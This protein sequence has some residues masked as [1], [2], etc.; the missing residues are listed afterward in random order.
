[1]TE[2]SLESLV[3]E[4]L[5]LRVSDP[6]V[7]PE[8]F[9]AL[10]PASPQLPG[11][12]RSALEIE[13]LF[14]G[15]PPTPDAIGA[16][17]VVSELGRGGMGIVYRVEKG[18]REFA[19]KLLPMAPLVGPRI[20]E[21]FRREA[22]N[23]AQ[24]HHSSIVR[25]HET[26]LHGGMPYLVMDLVDG[27][28][29]NRHAE[30]LSI[31]AAA[32]LVREL[33]AA[34]QVV[35]DSGVLHRD[36]KP[37]NVL[38][39]ADGTTVL[40]DFG[41]SVNADVSG[42]TMTGEILGTPRYMAPEQVSAGVVDERTDVHALG[43]I[44][45]ELV[46]Q[47]PARSEASRD[48]VLRAARLGRIPRPRRVNGEIRAHL[49]RIVLTALAQKPEDRYESARAMGEDLD[50]YLSG[51]PVV[52]KNPGITWEI[53]ELVSA[54]P[55]RVTKVAVSV[56]VLG[57][58]AL[59]LTTPRPPSQADVA[60]A[61]RDR[62]QGIALW[63]DGREES[64]RSVLVRSLKRNPGDPAAVAL[65]RHLGGV[66]GRCM[67]S[68]VS[69]SAEQA[70]RLYAEGEFAAAGST[71]RS[72]PQADR[73]GALAG[74]VAALCTMESGDL[75][76]AQAELTLASR[77]LPA[78]VTLQRR[79]GRVYVRTGRLEEAERVFGHVTTL[80]PDSARSW[81]DLADV[82]LRRR[83]IEAGQ[84]AIDRALLID[85]D[86]P[87]SL[88]VLANLK[89]LSGEG[90][91][92]RGILS[93]LAEMRP[94]DPSIW[95]DLG[96][97]HDLD[98]DIVGAEKAYSRAVQLDTGHARALLCL[99]NL[100]AGASRGKCKGCDAAYAAHPEYIDL[101]KAETYL[102]RNLESDRARDAWSAQTALDIAL[103]LENRNRVIALLERLTAVPDKTGPII[104]LQEILG[105]L[106]LAEGR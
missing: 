60:A 14:G 12:I 26:G 49:E 16:Y 68:A 54:Y 101:A 34:V 2:E 21:R 77:R 8:S 82:G 24:L 19:L 39:R 6:T 95:F 69:D 15:L 64:A 87:T 37:Q 53:S 27:I 103:L 97:S 92:A 22:E 104:R 71:L 44:L 29:L 84:K 96:Y 52:A 105:R 81:R 75:T 5:D 88:R 78:S 7:T 85:P 43:L 91:E 62:D 17:R 65:A 48:A 55:A 98:H 61:V 80:Q 67:R 35:H 106:R 51:N 56:L 74:A 93:R 99:A 57:G 10:H 50:R 20:L 30:S 33:C 47:K 31:E 41:L 83:N 72:L 90:G 18:G 59:L 100:Y 79:L 70:L 94:D 1:M 102:L 23:L 89:T 40:V 73:E 36:L 66:R 42:M 86:D 38:V 58:L 9:A 32:R 45:Y 25:V 76:A 13:S 46:T 11:A 28:P 3:A 4:F 63:L